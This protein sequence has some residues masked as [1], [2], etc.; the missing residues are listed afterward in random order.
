[1]KSL[2]TVNRLRSE[3]YDVGRLMSP[4]FYSFDTDDG[5]WAADNDAFSGFHEARYLDMLEALKGRAGCLFVTA[6]DV[7][8]ERDAT[9]ER[10]QLWAPLIADRGLPAGYVCQDGEDGSTI[11]SSAK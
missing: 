6:P 7:V 8:G 10:W 2:A 4:R 11:P 9:L 1:M 5:P 3:G